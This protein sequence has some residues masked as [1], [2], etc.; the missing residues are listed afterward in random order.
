MRVEGRDVAVTGNLL[1]PLTRRTNDILRLVLAT[2][3]LA[4][5]IT[6]SLVTRYEWVAL[7]RSVSQI[8]GVLSPPTPTWSTSPTASR[9]W[10]CRSRS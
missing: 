1:Q 8:V 5:V 2:L 10:R 6:S 4:T 3:F 7:E 9:S